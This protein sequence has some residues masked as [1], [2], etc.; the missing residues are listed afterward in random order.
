[1]KE[2]INLLFIRLLRVLTIIPLVFY[3][4]IGGML[5]ITFFPLM[6]I[7]TGSWYNDYYDDWGYKILDFIYD[8]N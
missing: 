4:F 6:W 7:I 8:G 1:M 5:R 2:R 3:I